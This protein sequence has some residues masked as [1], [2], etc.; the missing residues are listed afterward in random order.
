MVWAGEEGDNRRFN[1][2]DIEPLHLKFVCLTDSKP[3]TETLV[4]GNGES[5]T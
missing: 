3:I 2:D 5:F 1:K 4:V